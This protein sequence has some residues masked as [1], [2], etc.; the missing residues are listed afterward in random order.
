MARGLALVLVACAGIAAAQEPPGEDRPPERP[1]APAGDAPVEEAA[2]EPP[3]PSTEPDAPPEETEDTETRESF[4]PPMPPRHF[5]LRESDAEY[6]ACRLSLSLLGTRYEEQPPLTD[7]EIADCGIA[8]PILVT[9]VIPGVELEGGAVMRCDTARA[10]GFWTRD[11]LLPAAAA[12]PGAPRLQAMQLGTTYDCRARVG[13]GDD[14]PDLSEHAFGNAIDIMAFRFDQGEPL[15]IQPRAGD[16][17]ANEAFQRA[18]RA[19]ACLWFTT[20]MG[21]GSNAAHDDHLHLD[22]IPRPSGWRLCD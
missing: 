4:G 9:Q 18:A 20:V 10:L 2:P 13:T 19:T 3:T 15:P 8:R 6:A 7:P 5:Q 11:F 14:T 21:P 17:D 22:V 16:G 1:E 12:L